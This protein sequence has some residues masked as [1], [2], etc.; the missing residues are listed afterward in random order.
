[1]AV[2]KRQEVLLRSLKGY[3]NENPESMR[4]MYDIVSGSGM[5]LRIIDFLCTNYAKTR[6]VVYYIDRKP[7]NLFLAYK[8]QLKAYS[9]MQFDPF[10]RHERIHI[11]CPYADTKR[12]ETTVA[13]LNFFKWAIENKVVEY[14]IKNLTDI[15]KIMNLTTKKTKELSDSIK[16]T[17][18]RHDV[19]VT[20]TF[21]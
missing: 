5:S 11:S 8:G 12:L 14:C 13:Q 19:T 4:K 21:S 10:R 7:F 3:Y 18:K 16:K 9:K 6:D 15:E 2:Q 1:M 20:V 17:A